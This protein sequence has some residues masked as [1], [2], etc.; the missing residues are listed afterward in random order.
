M[1]SLH[2]LSDLEATELAMISQTHFTVNAIPS[3]QGG[4]TRQTRDM[5]ELLV[6]ICG[7]R[8]GDQEWVI[9]SNTAL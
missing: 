2:L 6:C 7:S 3:C 5:A 8:V 1:Y 4:C 9:G